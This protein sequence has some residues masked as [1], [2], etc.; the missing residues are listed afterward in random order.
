MLILDHEKY[1]GGDAIAYG[2]NE[3]DKG[4]INNTPLHSSKW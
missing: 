2:A 3:L 1:Q 4:V